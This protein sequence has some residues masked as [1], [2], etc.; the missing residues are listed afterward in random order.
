MIQSKQVPLR[1]ARVVLARSGPQKRFIRSSLISSHQ[2]NSDK[3]H[4]S[5]DLIDCCGF[6]PEQ[7]LWRIL[8]RLW[9]FLTPSREAQFKI[10]SSCSNG[11]A[12]VSLAAAEAGK[13]SSIGRCRKVLAPTLQL[14]RPV[15]WRSSQPASFPTTIAEPINVAHPLLPLIFANQNYLF[16]NCLIRSLSSSSSSSIAGWG[17]LARLCSVMLDQEQRGA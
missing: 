13:F 3:S 17:R 15:A 10:P 14:G 1:G 6:L 12:T 8:S 11:V 9:L 7:W 5:I 4:T 16:W 2:A